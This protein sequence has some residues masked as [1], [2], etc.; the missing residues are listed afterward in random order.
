MPNTSAKDVAIDLDE[1]LDRLARNGERIVVERDGRPAAI[2][3]PLEEPAARR[4]PAP[5]GLA[6]SEAHL[7]AIIDHAPVDIGL[8]DA[9]GRYVVVSRRFQ[10]LNGVTNDEVA[11]KTARTANVRAALALVERGEATAAIVYQSDLEIAPRVRVAAVFPV[12]LHP[13]ITY[14]LALVAGRRT[15]AA[16]AFHRFLQGAEAQAIFIAHG[17]RP[18]GDA[19]GEID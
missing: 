1:L 13:T 6:A 4:D 8:K 11:G 3:A 19:A 15:P 17:F 5:S 10:E 16:A 18:L 9:I 12:G 14:P 7:K 2:L